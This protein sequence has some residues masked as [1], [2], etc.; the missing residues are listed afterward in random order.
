MDSRAQEILDFWFGEPGS[1]EYG[2][3]RKLW[4]TKSDD[5]DDSI[6][7]QFGAD[8]TAAHSGDYDVWT[9]AS[10]PAR[11]TLAYI[12][13]LDQFTRN[14]YRDTGDMYIGDDRALSAAQQLVA[15]EKDITLEPVERVFCYLPYEH[16]EDLAVQNE[17]LR[18]FGLLAGQSAGG[19]FIQYAKAHHV[20]IERFGRFPHRNAL[21][22]RES[23]EAEIAFLK[24]PGSS[25]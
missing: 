14:V 19:G 25:F 17:S 13:L 3:E 22:G 12:V 7:S 10:A 21:L 18:L 8:I 20:I 24:E 9:H 2:S 23:T 5:F 11:E 6:R 1:D 4:F 15:Q 16:S